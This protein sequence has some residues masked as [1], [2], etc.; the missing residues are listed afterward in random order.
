MVLV[1][2]KDH[3]FKL[4]MGGGLG[5]NTKYELLSL[6]G[7][8]QLTSIIGISDINIDGDSKFIIDWLNGSTILQVLLL[9][10][11]IQEI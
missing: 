9:N 10:Q 3:V 4:C 2:N 1:I 11:R 8:L 5:S 7:L 6:F